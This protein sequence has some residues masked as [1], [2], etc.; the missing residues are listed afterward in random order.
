MIEASANIGAQESGRVCSASHMCVNDEIVEKMVPTSPFYRHKE[1]QSTCTG[2]S[3]K[4]SSSPQIGGAQWVTT[5]ESTLWGT[6]EH[7]A[8]RGGCH[9][10]RPRSCGDH[11][12]VLAAS[13]GGMVAPVEGT[14]P[15]T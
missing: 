15:C 6:E 7:G 12:G 10:S 4:S 2:R 13:A 11:A 14:I 5:V 9:G 8:G 3:K 1:G